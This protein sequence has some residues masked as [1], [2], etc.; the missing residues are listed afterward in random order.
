MEPPPP[1]TPPLPPPPNP[2]VAAYRRVAAA[3]PT[4]AAAAMVRALAVAA[5]PAASAVLEDENL[6]RLILGLIGE[7]WEWTGGSDALGASA[8]VHATATCKRW[9]N[10]DLNSVWKQLVLARW[11]AAAAL[12][13][14]NFKLLYRS[15][16]VAL[17]FHQG[18]HQPDIHAAAS[19]DPADIQ[20]IVDMGILCNGGARRNIVSLVLDGPAARSLDV[21]APPAL[22]Q[23][24]SYSGPPYEEG[25]LGWTVNPRIDHMRSHLPLHKA[26]LPL[27]EAFRDAFS[28]GGAYLTLTAFRKSDQAMSV[29]IDADGHVEPE[30]GFGGLGEPNRVDFEKHAVALPG[31]MRPYNCN[32]RFG[33][34]VKPDGDDDAAAELDP[35]WV[36]GFDISKIDDGGEY[37][38]ATNMWKA[39][40]LLQW[41]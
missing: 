30:Y 7:Q 32:A 41:T 12:D 9:H 16:H 11:P 25:G 35:T 1:L 18:V 39:L 15:H 40:T 26:N 31:E 20:F 19:Q 29:L 3:S 34:L 28:E 23:L 10:M 37:I 36:F 27:R 13:V 38:S 24:Y 33:Y 5:R 21:P 4:D 17:Q 2:P 14:K 22:G 8:L 6:T